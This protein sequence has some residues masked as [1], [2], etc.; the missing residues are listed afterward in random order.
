MATNRGTR[1]EY[2]YERVT[3]VS[4]TMK[5]NPPVLVVTGIL[6]EEGLTDEQLHEIQETIFHRLNNSLEVACSSVPHTSVVGCHSYVHLD[7]TEENCFRC[8][9]CGRWTTNDEEPN[10]IQGLPFGRKCE[11]MFLCDECEC[12]KHDPNSGWT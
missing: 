4:K 11:G 8:Q 6:I 5:H 3:R 7:P 1:K 10:Q 2:F 9:H 12:W